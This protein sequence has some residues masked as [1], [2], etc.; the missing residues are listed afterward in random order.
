MVF[1]SVKKKMM[2]P[3]SLH[4]SR[5]TW[6]T[7]GLTGHHRFIL[8]LLSFNPKVVRFLPPLSYNTV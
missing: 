1:H 8:M 5:N 3:L 6:Q 7:Q 2:V 4:D